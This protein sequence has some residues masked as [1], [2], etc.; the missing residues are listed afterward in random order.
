MYLKSLQ[1]S[2]AIRAEHSYLALMSGERLQRHPAGVTPNLRRVV[3]RS[4]Q[5]EVAVC[6]YTKV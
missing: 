2:E 3:V 6:G 1:L 5:Q 4:C